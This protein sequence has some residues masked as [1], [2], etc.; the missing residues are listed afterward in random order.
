MM[1][2]LRKYKFYGIGEVL[3]KIFEEKFGLQFPISAKIR[4]EWGTKSEL[5]YWDRWLEAKGFDLPGENDFQQRILQKLEL[6]SEILDLLPNNSNIEILDVG[7]GPLTTL[8][9]VSKEKKINI[10]AIDPLADEYN[11][12]LSYHNIIP[13]VKT[14][15]IDV[16]DLSENFSK[17]A[18]D[19]IHAKNCIDHTYDPEKAILEMLKVLKKNC[20][21]LLVHKPNEAINQNWKGLHRWNFS[22]ED[23]NF[24]ISSKKNSTNF[25]Q[26]YKDFYEVNCTYSNN[27]LYLNTIIKK[28]TQK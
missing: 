26:K 23:G 12:L 16:M 1:N 15:K 24:I 14:Q 8:G 5:R 27:E 13:L 18:F 20:Y 28:V 7:S 6:Q 22:E 19:F 3:L 2:I 9:K 25:S 21:L 10:T 17:N 11:K 4:W